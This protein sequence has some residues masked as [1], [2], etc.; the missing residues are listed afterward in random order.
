MKGGLGL[1]LLVSA[2]A[3]AAAVTSELRYGAVRA[4]DEASSSGAGPRAVADADPSALRHEPPRP[5]RPLEDMSA[6]RERPLFFE[7][8]R[9]PE[10][11]SED[12]ASE[13]TSEPA[14]EATVDLGPVRLSAVVTDETQRTALIWNTDTNEITRAKVGET[15]SGWTVEEIRTSAVVLSSGGQRKELMLWDFDESPP[16]AANTRERRIERLR[17]LQAQRLQRQRE[18]VQA[19]VDK[20]RT[21]PP[22]VRRATPEAPGQTEAS[23]RSAPAPGTR[24][25]P[26]TGE[27]GTR[28]GPGTG[29]CGLSRC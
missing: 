25:G 16:P 8:R 4:G 1:L 14:P 29:D 24:A 22:N 5:V 7:D 9:Y 15:V 2:V 23:P 6:T 13:N 17:A 18:A 26:R 27:S 3:L 11:P 28:A 19:Q 10:A 20:A 12:T 21:E